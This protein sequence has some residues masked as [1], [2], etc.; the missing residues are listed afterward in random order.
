MLPP[1]YFD[2]AANDI[3]NLYSQLEQAIL[4][5]IVRRLVKTGDMTAM[6][7]WQAERLQE[8]GM[9]MDD[10]IQAVA[11]LTNASAA[12]VK[13][14]FEDAGVRSMQ[15]DFAIYEAAGLTPLPLKQSPAAA[16]IL[17]AGMQKTS[18]YLQNLTMTTAS[19][20]QQAY[21]QAATMAEMQVESGAFDYVTA[22]RHAVQQAAENGTTVLYPSGH[23]DH[24]DVAVRRA[25]LTGASQT[26]AQVSSGYMDDM[27]CDLVE[28]TAHPGAR[29]SHAVW[30]GHVFCRNGK[31]GKYLDF[32]SSTGYG[33]GAGLCGWNCRHS[34]FPFFE[35]LSESAYPRDKLKEYEDKA[36]TYNDQ[37][38]KYYDATQMQRV[39][40]RAIRATKRVL[41][42]YD[43]GMKS[44]DEKL[45][46]AFQEQFSASS[47]KLKQQE[48]ALKDFT[49][50]TGLDRQREREQS[51]GFSHSQSSKA[52]WAKKRVDIQRQNAIL[53][54]E[55]RRAGNLGKAAQIHLHPNRIEVSSF[56][57]DNKHINADRS[58]E[59]TRE[60]AEQ[61]IREALISVTVWNGEF[62]RYY[63]YYGTVYVNLKSKLIRTAYSQDQYS[64]T[65]R[66]LLEVLK[67]HGY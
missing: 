10:I 44:S 34:F 42:G 2:A 39:M 43:E 38:I 59:V 56:D 11:S 51:L 9:L 19:T 15:T 12:Q 32:V 58:H 41:A 40:E 23:S 16:R 13:A 64:D 14:L 17:Q 20:G 18:G 62:E 5:D 8:T 54:E 61:W 60:Q 28:T 21:I 4:R 35:G 46:N 50:Q 48:A 49:R 33:T 36:V 1:Y 30:Q 45:R 67:N 27:G 24:L 63:G 53:K 65:V 26:A 55:I 22:I 6:S 25:V 3:L 57:F 7:V 47:V 31:R 66:T 52:V 29:P 37:T